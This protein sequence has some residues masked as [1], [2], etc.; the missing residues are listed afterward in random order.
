LEEKGEAE[1]NAAQARAGRLQ[2]TRLTQEADN[3]VAPKPSAPTITL[4]AASAAASS[5]PIVGIGAS[6]G[7]L[8][9]FRRLLG[10]LAHDTGM[11]YVLVQH[12]DPNH[13]SILAELLSEATRMEVSEVKGDMRV[14][15]NH[16]YV[17]PPSKG[18][19]LVDGM[20]KLVPRG[21]A[22]SVHMTIDSF[23]RSLADVQGSQAIGVILSGM[24]SD[25]TLG[26][27]A[28]EA[29]GGIAFAQ[30]PASA[31][32]DGM[33]RSAI[34]AGGV[35]FVLAPEDIARQLTRLG[36]H[37]YLAAGQQ[38]RAPGGAPADSPEDADKDEDH[39]G[40]GRV[41]KAL[42]QAGGTDFNAYKETTL[43]RR[44][45]RRM[46]VNQIASF[47]DY[48]QHLEGNAAEAKALYE[49]CLISVTSFFRDRRFSRH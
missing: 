13:E 2:G 6:A 44:I 42:R 40:L 35:D 34:V 14:E 43:R 20:L 38:T 33:P 41:L 39:E 47:D 22:G 46:A 45:A 23:L 16:V 3:A 1:E 48:A 49:E 4:G 19:I 27:Q 21:P 30:D 36:H 15:P 18:L 8:D 11:A 12:L 5:F 17:I 29:E 31:K 32:S 7:G 28:I 26:L 37:P 25:G 9:A 24:G 10:A